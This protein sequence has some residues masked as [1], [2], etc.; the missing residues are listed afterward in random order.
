MSIETVPVSEAS[1]ITQH[2]ILKDMQTVP[3]AKIILETIN[4]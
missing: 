3:K 4:Y 2:K 1:R